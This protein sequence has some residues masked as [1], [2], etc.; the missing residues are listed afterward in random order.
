MAPICIDMACPWPKRQTGFEGVPRSR[1][2]RKNPC[3]QLMRRWL[4]FLPLA[5]PAILV[6]CT[7]DHD[8]STG[9]PSFYRKLTEPGAQVDAAAAA[10]MISGY[11]AN[12]GL[13]SVSVDPDLTELAQA[14]ARALASRDKLDQNVARSL[15]ERL[16]AR[17]YRA[18]VAAENIGAGYY[19]LAEAFSGWRDSPPHRANLLLAGATRMGIAAVY[20]PNTKYKVF[21]AL[22]LAAPGQPRG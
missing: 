20:A 22:I 15:D 19:T 21:W 10:S 5:L 13:T 14:Q 11:R 16:K 2:I 17:G 12:N 1:N 4:C 6:A 3:V 9:E 7:G 8:A 18:S